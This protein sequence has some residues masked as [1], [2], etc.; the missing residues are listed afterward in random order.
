M[1]K[2]KTPNTPKFEENPYILLLEHFMRKEDET[3][4]LQDAENFVNAF[5]QGK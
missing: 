2:L 1:E 5:Y 4:M 3:F